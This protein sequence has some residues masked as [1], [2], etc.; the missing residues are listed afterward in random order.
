MAE[1]PLSP[2]DLDSIVY[3]VAVEYIEHKAING[4]IEETTEEVIKDVISDVVFIINSYMTNFND[5]INKVQLTHA[6]TF[7]TN[8]E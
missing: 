2:Q 6:S 8:L 5:T 4:L 7:K 3:S 1:V